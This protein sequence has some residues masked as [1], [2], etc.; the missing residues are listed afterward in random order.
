MRR[1]RNLVLK[2]MLDL[3]VAVPLLLLLAPVIL[4]AMVW[5]WLTEGRPIFYVSTRYIGLNKPVRII[6]LRT[7]V[8]DASSPRYRLKERFMKDGY[9]DIPIECEVYTPIGR[10][11]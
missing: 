4:G 7:M 3:A 10:I 2:R 11:L 5:L 9:L 8:R 1:V 6:K